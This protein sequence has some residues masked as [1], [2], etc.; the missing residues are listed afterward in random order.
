MKKALIAVVVVVLLAP[1][2]MFVGPLASV[3]VFAGAN[4]S[5]NAC[6]SPIGV[7]A[8]LGGPVR[9]PL[10]GEFTVTSE[11]GMRYNPGQINHGQYRLHAGIDLVASSGQVVAA[12]DGVVADTPTSATGGNM[13]KVDHGGGLVTYYLHLASRTVEVGDVVWAGRPIGVQG[14]T[15]NVAGEHLHFEVH[16][17]GRPQDPRVWLTQRGLTVPPLG[18]QGRAPAAELVDPGGLDLDPSPAFL[19][20]TTTA[21]QTRQLT[22][23]LPAQVGQWNRDQVAVAA[24]VIRAG[25][26]R[27]LD[28]KTITIAVM[29]AMAESSLTNLDHGDAVRGDTIGVFQ[30]GPERGPYAQRM[31]PYGAAGIFFDYLLR[32]PGYLDLEPT[33]AA[34][35]AQANADPY[36]YQPRW[37]DAVL[38]VSTLTADPALLESLSV[39]GPVTGC[40]NGG[41]APLEGTGDGTGQAIVDA[42]THYL[43]VP[44][45]WGGG[46]VNGPTL[47][48]YSSPSL[49][50][51]RTVGLDCSGLVMAAVYHATGITL[52]H[53]AE[54]QGKHPAGA[55]VPRDWTQMKPGDVISFSEDGSGAP[56]SFGHVGI[57]VGNGKMIHANRPGKP[58]EIIQLEG[59]SYFEPM[60]WNIRRYSTS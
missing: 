39:G 40:E 10:A 6:V 37:P 56:G 44:Y 31:D 22:S 58:V 45:S 3:L 20:P 38:M 35:K 51:S 13:I 26:D 7:L 23:E 34:H 47:G 2:V 42:A 15:G 1:A 21:G 48:T 27:G 24:Q 52:P 43:G 36:H 29:T 60:A 25:Q 14:S 5:Q 57:Y 59:S 50:G 18:G 49:D 17:A 16:Q 54:A 53:K 12:A 19:A 46:D 32:V 9:W 41:P 55:V 11:Y 4:A 8:P 28:A 30:E 33:I